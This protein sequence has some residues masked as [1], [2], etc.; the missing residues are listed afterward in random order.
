MPNSRPSRSRIGHG[1]QRGELLL[2]L[3]LPL[4]VGALFFGDCLDQPGFGI[5]GER[6]IAHQGGAGAGQCAGH[7]R[8][9]RVLD[10][11]FH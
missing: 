8:G 3:G 6:R 5:G 10:Q 2:Q 9:Q 11:P 7:V 1:P 4:L